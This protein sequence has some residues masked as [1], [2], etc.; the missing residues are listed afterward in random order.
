MLPSI[1]LFFPFINDNCVIVDVS[2]HC[3]NLSF[4]EFF[5]T[6]N[7]IEVLFYM[8]FF[9]NWMKLIKMVKIIFLKKKH[10]FTFNK[11]PKHYTKC[12]SIGS[13]KN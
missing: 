7:H 12:F 3:N 10:K 9:V 8:K 1:I 5:L 6:P 13:C 4:L 2:M 11:Q